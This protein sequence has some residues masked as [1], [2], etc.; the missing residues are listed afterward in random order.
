M[1]KTI[2]ITAGGIGKRMGT[3]IPKQFIELKGLPILMHTINQFVA[4]N[5]DI[6]IIVVLPK[7]HIEYWEKLVAKHQ[8]RIQ[9][10]IAEGGKERFHS[11]KNGLA[12]AK[13]DV[14]G[15]H[16]AVRPFISVE[17]INNCFKALN[18][19]HAVIPVV[20]LKESIRKINGQQS[21]SVNRENYK[22]VQTPQCF[23]K[24]TILKAYQQPFST[25]FTDDASVVEQ[26]NIPIHLVAGNDENIKITTPFDLE[27]A[28]ILIQ[29]TI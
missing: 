10:Q 1:T 27:I 26:L 13:G 14:I 11:I 3:D 2:I 6:Q 29:K 17:V 15:I 23:K 18:Q 4:Y 19:H 12:L 28:K 21:E 22:L 24:E 5:K 7:N 8:F 20:S 25:L 9:H 16:D